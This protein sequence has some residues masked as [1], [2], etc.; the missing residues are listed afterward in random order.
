M[1]VG[2]DSPV[3]VNVFDVGG[4]LV[5]QFEDRLPAGAGAVRWDGEDESGRPVTRGIYFM[6]VRTPLG[7]QMR[8]ILIAR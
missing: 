6:H 5:R 7:S 4:R 3:S 8:R 1:T 2:S